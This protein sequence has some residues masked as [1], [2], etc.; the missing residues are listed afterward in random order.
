[1]IGT[2]LGPGFAV[3][4]RTETGGARAI[5][6]DRYW[7]ALLECN[8]KRGMRF[9]RRCPRKSGRRILRPR[10][11]RRIWAQLIYTC[12]N[13]PLCVRGLG[14]SKQAFYKSQEDEESPVIKW[15]LVQA[16]CCKKAKMAMD[17]LDERL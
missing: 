17:D 7:W 10:Q 14:A 11:K 16:G 4:E 8:I 15:R 5:V 12:E 2:F 9:A 13:P 6:S 3:P 1:M